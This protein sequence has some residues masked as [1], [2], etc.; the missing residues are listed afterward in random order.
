[1]N[2]RTGP[3]GPLR[4]E[5]IDDPA[6][7]RI[8]RWEWSDVG[9]RRSGLPWL[10]IFLVVFGALLLLEQVVPGMEMAGSVLFL[11]VGLAF[12]AKWAIDRRT[13]SLYAGALV[14]ALAAPDI[15]EATGLVAGPGLGTLCLGIAFLAIAAVRAA[16]GSG[17]G[18]QLGL[19]AILAAIGGSQLALDDVGAY[20][21]PVVI[22]AAGVL[23]LARGVRN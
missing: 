10:G 11:A 18:W 3:G 5:V 23:L 4:G 1:M 16:Q 7:V 6:T 19:G 13:G 9:G 2:D 22:L 14:T 12:L 8:H 17:W 15:I 20:V 21:W